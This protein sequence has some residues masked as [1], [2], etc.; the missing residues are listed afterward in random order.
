MAKITISARRCRRCGVVGNATLPD[1]PQHR[2]QNLHGL[3]DRCANW[4][5][6]NPQKKIK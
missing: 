4:Q 2:K 6:K 3:C 1:T 5:T